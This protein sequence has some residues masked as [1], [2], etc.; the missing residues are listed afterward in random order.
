M[1]AMNESMS[2]AVNSTAPEP[3]L[4]LDLGNMN[5]TSDWDAAYQQ[6]LS[7]ALLF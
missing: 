3:L 6:A 1:F 4:F 2:D 7:A 5:S